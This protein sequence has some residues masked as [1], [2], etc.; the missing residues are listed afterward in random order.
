MIFKLPYEHSFNLNNHFFFFSKGN[1]SPNFVQK[2][3]Y[4]HYTGNKKKTK[5][6]GKDILFYS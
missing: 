6:V 3:A 5:I 4:A 2:L 1:S